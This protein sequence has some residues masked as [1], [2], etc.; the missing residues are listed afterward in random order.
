M[1]NFTVKDYRIEKQHNGIPI[2]YEVKLTFKVKNPLIKGDMIANISGDLWLVVKSMSKY[3]IVI[4]VEDD[5][6]VRS[7]IGL[8]GMKGQFKIED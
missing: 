4:N 5:S 2:H 3:V 8:W 7:M 6:T 1:E